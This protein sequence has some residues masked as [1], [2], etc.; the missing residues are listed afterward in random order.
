[1]PQVPQNPLVHNAPQRT[2]FFVE[3]VTILRI[4][5]FEGEEVV[6]PFADLLAYLLHRAARRSRSYALKTWLAALPDH[7]A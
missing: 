7:H 6:L 5:T 4:L 3:D 2:L 1:M